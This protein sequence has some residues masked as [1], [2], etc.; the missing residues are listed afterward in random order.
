[1]LKALGLGARNLLACA[2]NTRFSLRSF[3]DYENAAAL[4]RQLEGY[5]EGWYACALSGA[6]ATT[7]QSADGADMR[8]LPEP[9]TATWAANELGR[10]A[11][12]DGVERLAS[13]FGNLAGSPSVWTR[14]TAI[15]PSG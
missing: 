7:A 6:S 9:R 12:T 14:F 8:G 15:S 5:L 11:V 4:Y 2:D 3:E 10:A 1:M 13:H